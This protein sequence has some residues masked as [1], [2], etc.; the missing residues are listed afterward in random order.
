M[1]RLIFQSIL[2]IGL[3]LS[4]IAVNA[5]RPLNYESPIRQYNTAL[6]LM[7]K[8]E[9]GSAQEY[10]QYVYE[11]TTDEQYDMKS[12]SYFYQGVCAAKLNHGNAMYLLRD[13][14]RRYPIH[15]RVPEA[16]L[17]IARS[18]FYQKQYKKALEY[19]NELDER[20]IQD[21]DLAEFYFK[22]GFC[23]LKSKD[24]DE[25]KYYLRK[26]REYDGQYKDKA[27]YYVAHLEYEEGQYEAALAD[28]NE[29]KDVK[30]YAKVVPPY[31]MQIHF[32]QGEY[33]TVVREAGNAGA[34]A[35][36]PNE[37]KRI[38]GLSHYNLSH[39]Q[40]AANYFAQILQKRSA[41]DAST[42]DR[43]DR[44]AFGYT[45]YK[46]G[47][48]SDAIAQLSQVTDTVD[49]MTQNAYYIIADC[50]L[51]QKKLADAS[52]YFFEA[53]KM[54]Y[55]SAIQEDAFYN[56]AKLQYETSNAISQDKALATI[57]EYINR[58]PNTSRSQ[59]MSS[60]L[61]T[62]YASTKNY[63][64]A[65]KAIE[66]LDRTH[67]SPEILRSYQRCTHFRAMELISDKKYRDAVKMLDKSLQTPMNTE[68]HLSNLYWKAESQYRAEQY[69]D[70]YN[71]FILYQNSDKVTA[72]ENYPLSLYSQGYAAMKIE[73]YKEGQKSFEKFLTFCNTD[74][75]SSYKADAYARLGDCYFMQR[76]LQSAIT[77]YERCEQLKSNN[78]DYALYQ[79]AL[80]QGYLR[81]SS[82][83]VELLEKFTQYYSNSPYIIDVEF[84][85]AGIYQAQNQHN[86]AINSYN[87]FIRKHPKSNY[88][89]KAYNKLAQAYQSAGQTDKAIETFKLVV[90]KYP[91][92]QEAKEAVSN[93]Q[94]IY[95]EMGR[96]GDFLD[97]VTSKGNISISP[98][99]QD[100]ITY[101][102]AEA[103]YLQGNCEMA[104]AG[105]TEYINKFPNGF[106]IAD[107]YFKRSDCEYG[108]RNYDDALTDCEYLLNNFRTENN[109]LAAKRAATIL[110]NKQ[111]YD[112][113]LAHFNDLLTLSTS[114]MNTSYAYNGIMRC[115]FELK[116]YREAL[117][118][119]KGY[120]ASPKADPDLM[121]DAN[122][123]AGKSSFELRDYSAAIRYLQPLSTAST[124]STAAEAAYYCALTEFKRA[125]YT[126]CEKKITEIIEARYTS[127]YWIA[128]TFILYG[129]YYKAIGNTFQA[130]HTYQ[131]I[132]D[133]YD[134]EDLRQIARERIA[135]L[136]A[137]NTPP[138]PTPSN[139]D[140]DD[141]LNPED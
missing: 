66:K 76:N 26:A 63:D 17:Y 11:N 72:D 105:F 13:F 118:G 127:A 20:K 60:Y 18:Y 87:S 111:E 29:I 95:S 1:K 71:S 9:Y 123:I 97:Y 80:C 3:M 69:Q 124:N 43:A 2:I 32:M 4:Q 101:K 115:A 119:A 92:S 51:K 140:D 35:G 46:T 113:A 125:D 73:K 5:Q 54:E 132:V 28:F 133:N 19:F 116:N 99:R 128:S 138:T 74:K 86:L 21:E 68:L 34:Q 89:P 64:G 141:S 45:F 103:K 47:D 110:F 134:G 27:T 38:V 44:Y 120:I 79:Q 108:N 52:N 96:P 139:D 112:R 107:A 23:L 58:Y 14:V 30:E 8:H 77:Q 12:T 49:A 100:S 117:E 67:K 82:K 24:R 33:E 40:E 93:L 130:R 122:L 129:D 81:H 31:I 42:Y 39:Y 136:D 10:F 61:A 83:K 137:A 56:Y 85:L 94:D 70:A 121:D 48:Y 78:A 22:K 59:E 37:L 98:E 114:E 6:E 15:T 90:D 75:Y 84:E 53:S 88:V 109:E 7:Q 131:S 55:S 135:A 16:H 62:I 41:N 36:D 50:F 25:A 102:S 57:E 126:A 91:G 106:F 65:I 104:I